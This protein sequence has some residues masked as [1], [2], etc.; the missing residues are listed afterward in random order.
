MNATAESILSEMQA[1]QSMMSVTSSDDHSHLQRK[2]DLANASLAEARN[3]SMEE[4]R[5]SRTDMAKMSSELNSKLSSLQHFN[6]QLTASIKD[7]QGTIDVRELSIS[8]MT[9]FSI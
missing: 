9:T 2:L 5:Q 6:N 7:Q 1:E 4:L 3:Q 8:V